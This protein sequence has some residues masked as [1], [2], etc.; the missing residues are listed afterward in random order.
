[1][2][3]NIHCG[4]H[5]FPTKRS[6]VSKKQTDQNTSEHKVPPAEA[7]AGERTRIATPHVNK[8]SQNKNLLFVFPFSWNFHFHCCTCCPVMTSTDYGQSLWNLGGFYKYILSV[9]YFNVFSF[10]CNSCICKFCK[11]LIVYVV[12]L[13]NRHTMTLMQAD[14]HHYI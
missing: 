14:F 10:I 6:I 1:M 13:Q 4:Y 8:G 2:R 3:I 9:L 7:L 11:L 5:W 12:S